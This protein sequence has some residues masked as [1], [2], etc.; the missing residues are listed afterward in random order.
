MKESKVSSNKMVGDTSCLIQY[1]Y[2]ARENV[3]GFF[4]GVLGNVACGPCLDAIKSGG[5]ISGGIGGLSSDSTTR[6]THF[7]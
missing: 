7:V 1:I 6:L 3:F 2:L 5:Q 4:V